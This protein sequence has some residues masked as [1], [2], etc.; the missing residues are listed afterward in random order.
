MIL[1]KACK[2]F[3]MPIIYNYCQGKMA[4]TLRVVCTFPNKLELTSFVFNNISGN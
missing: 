1:R 2:I 4:N 3:H